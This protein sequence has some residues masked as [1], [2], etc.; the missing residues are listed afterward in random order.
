MEQHKAVCF[1]GVKDGSQ[2]STDAK[3]NS[4][5]GDAVDKINA[6]KEEVSVTKES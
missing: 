5:G 2:D 3:S 1:Y 4:E 6:A